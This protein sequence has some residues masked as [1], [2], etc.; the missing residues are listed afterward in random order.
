RSM[1]LNMAIPL[2]IVFRF[3][4]SPMIERQVTVF[5]EP[6]SP[7]MP[8]VWPFSIEKLTPST[9]LTMPSSVRKCVFRSW[10]SSSATLC[11][12]VSL[13]CHTRLRHHSTPA[14]LY[15]GES[16]LRVDPALE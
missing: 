16:D 7:T 5:P 12:L 9:A 10:T 15:L 3:G 4:F 8:R 6:D 2:D 13:T 1:S 14:E 11:V